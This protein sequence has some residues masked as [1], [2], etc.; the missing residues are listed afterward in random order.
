MGFTTKDAE[1]RERRRIGEELQSG[2]T[3]D[4]KE[5]V[6]EDAFLSRDYH[7]EQTVQEGEQWYFATAFGDEMLT[8]DEK[9]WAQ[10]GAPLPLEQIQE[11]IA[12]SS[13]GKRERARKKTEYEANLRRFREVQAH[14]AGRK[15]MAKKQETWL[16]RE[17][18]QKR[19]SDAKLPGAFEDVKNEKF[20]WIDVP[21]ARHEDSEAGQAARNKQVEFMETMTK[22]RESLLDEKR[23]PAE[24]AVRTGALTAV[25]R[26]L[27]QVVNSYALNE[28]EMKALDSIA[29]GD[30]AQ[31]S[32]TKTIIDRKK[33][34]QKSIASKLYEE[35]KKISEILDHDK[36]GAEFTEEREVRYLQLCGTDAAALRTADPVPVVLDTEVVALA[37]DELTDE[38]IQNDEICAGLEIEIKNNKEQLERILAAILDV[39]KPLPKTERK[40]LVGKATALLAENAKKLSEIRSPEP[41]GENADDTAQRK[42]RRDAKLYE[43]RNLAFKAN[44]VVLNEQIMKVRLASFERAKKIRFS[45]D[46]ESVKTARDFMNRKFPKIEMSD[47]E[48]EKFR[49]EALS[50]SEETRIDLEKDLGKFSWAKEP[51]ALTKASAMSI[52]M[53]IDTLRKQGRRVLLDDDLTAFEGKLDGIVS[54]QLENFKREFLG[55]DYLPRD[56]KKGAAAAKS[57]DTFLTVSGLHPGV[58]QKLGELKP[59][60]RIPLLVKIASKSRFA[61]AGAIDALLISGEELDETALVLK[62]QAIDGKFGAKVHVSKHEHKQQLIA[63]ENAYKLFGAHDAGRIL[64]TLREQVQAQVPDLPDSPYRTRMKKLLTEA[65]DKVFLRSLMLG[66][67]EDTAPEDKF[68]LLNTYAL[69]KQAELGRLTKPED[70][71]DELQGLATETEIEGA[72]KSKLAYEKDHND[73]LKALGDQSSVYD[74][75]RFGNRF[76]NLFGTVLGKDLSAEAMGM[77]V[78]RDM[79]MPPGYKDA[80]EVL[81]RLMQDHL[82]VNFARD[83]ALKESFLARTITNDPETVM[84]FL[85]KPTDIATA[86]T[87][88]KLRFAAAAAERERMA[89]ELKKKGITENET[90][91]ELIMR[92]RVER[93]NVYGDKDDEEGIGIA[94][95]VLAI[96]KFLTEAQAGGS[97]GGEAVAWQ[98]LQGAIGRIRE[99]MPKQ[100]NL[101]AMTEDTSR[102]KDTDIFIM[103]REFKEYM[104]NLAGAKT[105]GKFKEL[106]IKFQEFYEKHSLESRAEAAVAAS[107]KTKDEYADVLRESV[108]GNM[109]VIAQAKESNSDKAIRKVMARM[110]TS[111]EV[112][113]KLS[114]A[115]MLGGKSAEDRLKVFFMYD[116]ELANNI[117]AATQMT[118][119]HIFQSQQPPISFDDFMK[120]L[121]E[122][123]SAAFLECLPMLTNGLREV[124]TRPEP[125]ATEMVK[126]LSTKQ[127]GALAES[128]LFAFAHKLNYDTGV[129]PGVWLSNLAKSEESEESRQLSVMT[130]DGNKEGVGALRD[131]FKS[132]TVEA[133]IGQLKT[134]QM[135]TLKNTTKVGATVEY[136][137]AEIEGS[138]SLSVA[139]GNDLTIQKEKNGAYS[140]YVGGEVAVAVGAEV[141]ADFAGVVTAKAGVQADVARAKG[142]RLTLAD[143]ADAAAFMKQMVGVKQAPPKTT[144]GPVPSESKEESMLHRASKIVPITNV[145]GNLTLTAGIELTD[146]AKSIGENAVKLMEKIGV[147]DPENADKTKTLTER[148]QF[149]LNMAASLSIGGGFRHEK[150]GLN[151]DTTVTTFRSKAEASVTAAFR[152]GKVELKAEKE[153]TAALERRMTGGK[154]TGATLRRIYNLSGS[155]AAGDAKDILAEYGVANTALYQDLGGEL[156]G[157]EDMVLTFDAELTPAGLLKYQEAL[158]SDIPLESFFVLTDRENYVGKGLTLEVKLNESTVQS[159]F[160]R[161][162]D[163]VEEDEEGEQLIE[164][165]KLGISIERKASANIT[166][167]L[168]YAVRGAPRT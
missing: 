26:R 141:S 104:D 94:L 154:L 107:T 25:S 140:V 64:R 136:E 95:P 96:R 111:S 30:A 149:D 117:M 103:R 76:W 74:S 164:S 155:G 1:M 77:R 70:L 53:Q 125:P 28:R 73:V 157:I 143:A 153:C 124:Q 24:N 135:L 134:N 85:V 42:Y 34:V 51:L 59:A 84:S 21:F 119:L 71:K 137:M 68:L 39:R 92:G 162:S 146:T 116:G 47:E 4:S 152:S 99:N 108:S 35:M 61:S 158:K 27:A 83:F 54:G 20:A 79:T 132:D 46:R 12:D 3:V 101:M 40:S 127:A 112:F 22:M 14:N 159:T 10:R 122:R 161:E 45:A 52:G 167:K 13:G 17:I 168:H 11:P 5:F 97:L 88:S 9:Y 102:H 16:E 126:P 147:P 86:A 67:K 29:E 50:I 133:I 123:D 93:A 63:E 72:L 98:D 109:P 163:L 110:G 156:K 115:S 113:A 48:R 66:R 129:A 120:S 87:A 90:G 23:K 2:I 55:E 41:P 37:E 57:L 139:A 58:A 65:D 32:V 106:V 128:M 15:A 78:L 131:V 18:L 6:E 89:E 8:M 114:T 150:T 75:D 69:L 144:E 145:D 62:Q 44:E 80:N 19:K 31:E 160:G 60:K 38:E 56:A 105:E 165:A 49:K 36:S 100:Y 130:L 142:F 82:R 151:T 91:R 166:Q 148:Q 118:V 121:T 138:V 81:H 7:T 33:A 43:A